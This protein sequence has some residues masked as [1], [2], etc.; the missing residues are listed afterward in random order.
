MGVVR[1]SAKG[2]V[3]IPLEVLEQA[4]LLPLTE[5]D[6]IVEADG[7]R[8][9]KA[10]HPRGPSRGDLMVRRMKRAAGHVTMT[11]DEVM[12]LTRGED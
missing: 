12:A 4:G 11:T 1:V 7:V 3:T 2:R 9:V 6:F 10:K 5:V 8:I